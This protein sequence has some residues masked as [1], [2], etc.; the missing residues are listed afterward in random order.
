MAYNASDICRKL[1]ALLINAKE[2]SV[3]HSSISL[4]ISTI[5]SCKILVNSR[6]FGVKDGILDVL[7]SLIYSIRSYKPEVLLEEFHKAEEFV[8]VVDMGKPEFPKPKTPE[9]PEIPYADM[10][11][12]KY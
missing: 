11:E 7:E 2:L 1:I 9:I 10:M 6:N 4:A 3:D 8:I 5:E 12:S